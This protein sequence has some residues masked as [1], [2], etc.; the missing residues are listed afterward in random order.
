MDKKKSKWLKRNGYKPITDDVIREM[1]DQIY[2]QSPQL[3][4]RWETESKERYSHYKRYGKMIMPYSLEYLEMISIEELK[5]YNRKN[6]LNFVIF[7]M[8]PVKQIY[9]WWVRK[10]RRAYLRK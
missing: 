7:G 4:R 5:K 10:Q 2:E 3:A 6:I 9:R 1:V 8:W